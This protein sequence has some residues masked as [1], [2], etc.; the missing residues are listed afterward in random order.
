M[1][2]ARKTTYR[3]SFPPSGYPRTFRIIGG[4][5]N[6]GKGKIKQTSPGKKISG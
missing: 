3:D 2:T 4:K 5:I 1:S 6:Q